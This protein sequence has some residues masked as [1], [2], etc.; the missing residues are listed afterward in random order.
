MIG[1]ID[2][3][4]AVRQ[5]VHLIRWTLLGAVV[6]VLAGGGSAAFLKSLEWA[7]RSRLHHEGLIYALPFAGAFV[8]LTYQKWGGRAALGTNLLIDEVH[9]VEHGVPVRMAPM[10]LVGATITHLFGG[11]GGREGAAVQ[12]AAS[13]TDSL[14]KLVSPLTDFDDEA[15]RMLLIAATAGGF[16]AVFGVPVAGFVFAL[17]VMAVGRIR[18]DAAVPALAASA[19]GDRMTRALGIHHAPLTAI[20]VPDLTVLTGAR[21]MVAGLAFGLAALTFVELTHGLKRLLAKRIR[22]QWMRPALGG[23][24]VLGMTLAV[25]TRDYNGLSLPLIDQALAGSTVVAVAFALKLLFTSVTIGSGFPGGEVTPLFCV[26][27]CLGNV[28]AVPLGIDRRTLAA[29]GFVAVYAAASNTP[30]TG[31]VLA[32]ELFGGRGLVLFA[33]VNLVAYQSSGHRSVYGRQRIVGPKGGLVHGHHTVSDAENARL[34]RRVSRDAPS[35]LPRPDESRTT[36][37]HRPRGSAT[38]PS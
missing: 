35:S 5:L 33:I 28:L 13:L 30:L 14:R 21:L 17:E 2:E 24:L 27:A 1:S 16:G 3:R 19:V 12:I 38:P 8:G 9:E 34:R 32:A 7:T 31:M 29:L 25:R 11:S 26:G 18:F 10:V 4:E 15:R 20:P 23:A 22:Q 37:D 6:G 36:G